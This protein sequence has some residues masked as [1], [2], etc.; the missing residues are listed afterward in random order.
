MIPRYRLYLRRFTRLIEANDNAADLAE[1]LM[2]GL[3]VGAMVGAFLWD[4]GS[5]VTFPY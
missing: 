4:T 5:T 2:M 1:M 3:A